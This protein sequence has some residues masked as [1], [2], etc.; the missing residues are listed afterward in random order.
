MVNGN[1]MSNLKEKKVGYKINSLQT[2]KSFQITY[3]LVGRVFTNGSGDLG[4]ILGRDTPPTL[5]MV[6]VTSLLIMYVSR[7]KWSNPGK[8]VVPSPTPSCSSH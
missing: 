6:L 7:V 4:S 8:G 1:K 3:S 5:K 2:M